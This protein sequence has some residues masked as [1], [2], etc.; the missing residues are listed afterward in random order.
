M[1]QSIL[2]DENDQCQFK[3]YLERSCL[4]Y[5]LGILGSVD[6]L[7]CELS[8]SDHYQHTGD[9]VFKKGFSYHPT[10][11]SVPII[12]RPLINCNGGRSFSVIKD[13]DWQ[14]SV[15][16]V[17]GRGGGGGGVGGWRGYILPCMPL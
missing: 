7:L 9:L 10:A 17:I 12:W 14:L 5:N 15:T 11:V 6:K 4:S 1:I 8:N 3:C 13:G 2:V 16:K